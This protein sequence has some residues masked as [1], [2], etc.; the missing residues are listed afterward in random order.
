[1]VEL[2][3]G[4]VLGLETVV[5]AISAG[6]VVVVV[7]G[8]VGVVT[9]PAGVLMVGPMMAAGPGGGQHSFL[10]AAISRTVPR[11][12]SSDTAARCSAKA[13]ASL[14]SFSQAVSWM[15]CVRTSS[16]CRCSWA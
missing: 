8:P 7:T 4:V 2:F 11:A 5:P 15:F 14:L 1:G 10:F 9:G 3:V 6:G 16:S 13:R 12:F